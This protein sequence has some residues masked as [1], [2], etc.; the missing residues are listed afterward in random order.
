MNRRV[1]RIQEQSGQV[2]ITGVIMLIVLLL[3]LV[4]I[5][6]VH[7]VIRA[8]F[9]FE[10]AQQSAAL[11]GAN[12]QKNTLNL[13]GEINLLKACA[14]MLEG[15]KNWDIPLPPAEDDDGIAR[16]MAIQGRLDQLTEMQTRVSFIGPIIGY[17]A[18]Q[19]AA[20]ANGMR[21]IK[22]NREEEKTALDSYMLRLQMR[23]L[24]GQ[25]T[26][27]NNYSWYQ[28]YVS[29]LNR[30]SGS[31]IAVLPNARGTGRPVASP[32]ALAQKSFYREILLHKNEIEQIR[33]KGKRA[34]GDQSSW[35]GLLYNFVR[36]YE[37]WSDHVLKD[38]RYWDI[39]F[40]HDRF[41]NESEIFSVGVQTGF[42]SN[43][44][45]EYEPTFSNHLAANDMNQDNMRY[46]DR[47]T[48]PGDMKWFCYDSTWYPQEYMASYADYQSEH[49]DYW[50]GGNAL[51]DKVK[52]KYIYEGAA[53][54]A[55]ASSLQVDRAINFRP[56]SK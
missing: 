15:E 48:L 10:T 22:S 38:T 53:A 27:I 8:K 52:E 9:K 7:N 26:P 32:S 23:L 14:V 44:N 31:G 18:A 16:R 1:T 43:Q 36:Y 28:P 46:P 54:Y 37:Q 51:R 5:F 39:D 42:S 29:M 20:K 41:P 50:F 45:W 56:E 25:V 6:D 40:N 2:I 12:W 33:T 47:F 19:Q 34:P 49:F 3:L 21:V 55:E 35:L 13:I 4:S 17:A 11:A 24:T 30:I